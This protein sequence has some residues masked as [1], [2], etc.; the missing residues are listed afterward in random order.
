MTNK[1]S[2]RFLGAA[3]TVTGSK[4]FLRAGDEA[5]LVDC[6]LFQGPKKLR[7]RNWQHLPIAKK[8]IDFIVLT[9][10][11]IDH[12]GYLPR[13][14]RNGYPNRIWGT[15]GTCDLLKVLLPDAAYLQEEQAEYA[16]RK[17][18]SKHKPA[19]P[20]FN[21]QDAEQTLQQLRQI[22]YREPTRMGKSFTVEFRRAGH[23][24]GS[25]IIIVTIDTGK[26]Q[27]RRIV[28]SGD[29]GRY[30]AP[31]LRD[32][33]PVEKADYLVV[34]STY[35]DRT[36]SRQ[37][38]PADLLAKIVNETIDSG[39]L[40]LVP[41]FAV[42]RT[43][44]L[45]YLLRQLEDSGQIPSLPIYLDSPMAIKASRF[46]LKHHEEY[47]EETLRLEALK[48]DPL[49]PDRI[50]FCVT[51]QESE[52]LNKIKHRAII[53]SA[54]GMLTGGRIL[55]HASVRLPDSRNTML[56]T[57]FQAAGTRGRRLLEGEEEIK[58]H[59]QMVPVKARVVQLNGLSA[60][61]DADEILKWVSSFK[62]PPEKTFVVHGEP[63]SSQALADRL[64]A[65]AGH[66]TLVPEHGDEVVL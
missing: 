17:G 5:M 9:H 42:G 15:S 12:S 35:G 13:L 20:L 32:P 21:K 16:N 56:L 34:E 24:L 46:H 27:P 8:E 40:L 26:G 63:T 10:A 50:H 28:F 22:P 14:V 36:H 37:P 64:K 57:G 49:L 60:H 29:L 6:G 53:I 4:F 47:D 3:G 66:N 51:R 43:Q 54:S 62:M 61:A 31:I 48:A 65:E 23:I 7:L 41:A 1:V 59:G 44:T 39:G 58:I 33:A 18:F 30:G 52:A 11:H 38:P 25:A 19:L 55:H 45:L 2:I